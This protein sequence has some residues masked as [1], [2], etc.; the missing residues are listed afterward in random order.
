MRIK[1]LLIKK[2]GKRQLEQVRTA[3]DIIGDV[4]IIEIPKTLISK[5]KIIAQAVLKTNPHI[6]T[7]AAKIGGHTGK[8]R[9]QKLKILAGEKK[10]VTTHREW[11][12]LYK[13]DVQNCYFSP[14][15]GTERMRIARLVQPKERVLVMF[16]GIAPFCLVIAK[17]SKARQVIGV[18]INPIAHKY[19]FENIEKN[20]LQNVKLYKG[21]VS[22]ILP[23]IGV[24]DRIIMPLPK[25]S[26][27]YFDTALLA[28]KKGTIIHVYVF[29]KQEMFEEKAK[30]VLKIC[31]RLKKTCKILN[32]TKTAQT[33]PRE[34]RI[35][36]DMQVC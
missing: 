15:T 18:E 29:A 5:E 36:I 6:K 1:E 34:Y 23:K 24:F 33:K 4:A 19:A 30:Q 7:V 32:I 16:S 26:T 9:V 13:L 17:Y 25:S 8:Y 20:K 11:G 2:L 31:A 27:R 28:A 12:L 14:R 10:S 3:H 21:S 35:C 22:R